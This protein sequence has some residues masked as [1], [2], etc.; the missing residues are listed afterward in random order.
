VQ[1]A[2]AKVADGHMVLIILL[3]LQTRRQLTPATKR[4]I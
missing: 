1:K 3:Q 4:Q 2:I